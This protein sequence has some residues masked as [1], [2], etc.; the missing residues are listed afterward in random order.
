MKTENTRK[1][2]QTE[3]V[4]KFSKEDYFDDCPICQAMKAAEN[5]RRELDEYE[6]KKAFAKAKERGGI[7]GGKWFEESK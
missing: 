6:L 2:I 3:L 4:E 7:V 1:K 5:E